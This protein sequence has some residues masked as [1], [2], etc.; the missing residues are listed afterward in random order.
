M[1]SI[2]ELGKVLRSAGGIF[3]P[4]VRKENMT[5][6]TELLEQNRIAKA[7]QEK[8]SIDRLKTLETN[9]K[10]S[11]KDFDANDPRRISGEEALKEIQSQLEI[12][13]VQPDPSPIPYPEKQQQKTSRIVS[14]NSDIGRQLGIPEGERAE[15]E[16][17]VRN[18]DGTYSASNISRFGGAGVEVNNITNPPLANIDKV[19]EGILKSV[20]ES[21]E[22]AVRQER[23]LTEVADI[24]SD[25]K[26][27]TGALQP[28]I[29]GLQGLADDLGVNLEGMASELG[30]NIGNLAS[31]QEFDRLTTEVIID[32]FD[33][34]KGNLNAQ[35]V[36]LA[37]SAFANFGKSEDANIMA[38]A[39]LLAS[40]RIAAKSAEDLQR[41]MFNGD[42]QGVADAVNRRFSTDVDEFKEMRDKIA[43]EIRGKREQG[44]VV[45]PQA[46]IDAGITPA[47]WAVM[48]EADRALFK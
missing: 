39:S 30:I 17:L 14:G 42:N 7:E 8:A 3:S 1:P 48:P 41:A 34:F 24:L 18:D 15:V 32:G 27:Q 38:T 11:L 33:K 28:A 16:N 25:P 6:R 5:L 43:S 9:M 44:K 47:M 46:A 37:V 13:G 35:E 12:R 29:T 36:R 4:E 20:I 40:A 22:V 45:L 23:S 31:K 21:G 26:V 19:G 2:E 10:E